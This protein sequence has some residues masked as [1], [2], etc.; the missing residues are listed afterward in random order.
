MVE[1][2]EG[3]A[4]IGRS[5]SCAVTLR[6]PSA[7]RNHVLVT[8][9][10]GE[11]RARDLQSSNGTYLNGERLTTERLLH[12]GDRITIG[13][14]DILVRITAPVMEEVGATVRLDTGKLACPACGA[15]VPLDAKVCAQCGHR[16]G[17][18]VVPVGVGAGSAPPPPPASEPGAPPSLP[19]PPPEP[20]R[21]AA[22][23]AFE[24]APALSLAPPVGAGAGEAAGGELLPPIADEVF[25]GSAPAPPP[26]PYR[27]ALQPTPPPQPMPA[28]PPAPPPPRAAV[29]ATPA[30]PPPIGS[31]AYAPA[32]AAYR[33]AGFWL[34]VVAQIIDEVWILAIAVGLTLVL[35]GIRSPTA[36]FLLSFLIVLLY[37]LV[38]LPCWAI[39]GATPGKALLGLRVVSG[40]RR[41]GLGFGLAF[42]R[43][44]GMMVSF[45]TF[46]LGFL[47]VAFTRDKRALH[48]HLAG[49]AVIRR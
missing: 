33:P 1:L 27:P 47:M 32:P 19:P 26:A 48:D 5:R 40:K 46:G 9:R 38:V 2:E 14:T 4:T 43:L 18:D 29:A 7:S 15:E 25:H 35:G 8:V 16:Q 12:D 31:P 6:D 30:A 11:V 34:R 3:E 28:M 22:T 36:P 44:C 20:P 42:L 49:T 24:A 23:E 41:K 39:F 13:E 37:V 45:A 10:T 17:S 21:A